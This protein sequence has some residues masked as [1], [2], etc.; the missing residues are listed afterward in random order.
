[1]NKLKIQV[2]LVSVRQGRNGEKIAKWAMDYLQSRAGSDAY[3]LE[4]VDLKDWQLPYYEEATPPSMIQGKYS[5]E[6]ALKW[7]AKIS[8]A[9]AYVIITPE[10]NH[11]YPAS[12]KNALDYLYTEWN[13]KAVSFI[14][15]GVSASGARANEQLKQ[16]VNELQLFATREEVNVPL[17]AGFEENGYPKNT[18][19]LNTKL[20]KMISKLVWLA[21]ALKNA[22]P[23]LPK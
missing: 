13:N 12:L 11:A 18:E 16:V 23:N 14:S 19:M 22:L 5:S 3:Q 7:S 15:Y 10:Y 17:M 9:D 1:M 21:T 4:L 8:E 20:E 6:P 2:I